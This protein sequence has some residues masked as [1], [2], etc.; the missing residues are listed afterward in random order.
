[1]TADI[2]TESAE[3]IKQ[4]VL[5]NAAAGIL[6]QANQESKIVLTLLDLPTL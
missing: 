2:A 3:L 5:R 4:N 6:A 1:M